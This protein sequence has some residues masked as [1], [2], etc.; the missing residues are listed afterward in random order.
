MGWT[1]YHASY[2]KNGKVDR[3][4]ECDDIFN[5][6][7]VTW[8]DDRKVIGKFEVLKSSMVG[9]TY[10]A[11]VKRTKF[12]TD[13][14]P[15]DVR[16]FAVI[17]LTSTNM[18]DYY[19]FAY[20]DMDESCG[21]GDCDCPKSILDL[22]SPTD[23]EWAND[24]RKACY[25]RIAK[26]KSKNSFNKLPV[27]TIIK[28]TMPCETNY[29]KQGQEVKLQKQLK[30]NSNRTQ[31]ITKTPP[32]CRFAPSLMKLLEESYEVIQRGEA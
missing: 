23:N 13:T 28:V 26:K 22:L 10:Y 32:M 7:M 21:P 30:W 11:A 24:W 9:S 27:G 2:Y 18:R 17:C 19:N 14:I 4:A 25:E 16:V 6:D 20:K 8:G 15:E 5:D 31:W 3:K 1:S 12:A 29:F